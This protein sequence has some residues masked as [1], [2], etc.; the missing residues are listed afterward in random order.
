MFTD[1]IGVRLPGY[2]RQLPP[3]WSVQT[4]L[5]TKHHSES[6]ENH[7]GSA[8]YHSD[9]TVLIGT[10]RILAALKSADTSVLRRM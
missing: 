7:S 8:D 9:S 3:K 6:T 4:I 10:W 2:I 1:D 5:P